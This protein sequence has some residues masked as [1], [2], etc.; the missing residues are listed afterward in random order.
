MICLSRLTMLHYC[1]CY[2]TATAAST[3]HTL[4]AAP[5]CDCKITSMQNSDSPQYTV[6]SKKRQLNITTCATN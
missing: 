6:K 2:T 1:M 4:Y 3:V 5:A